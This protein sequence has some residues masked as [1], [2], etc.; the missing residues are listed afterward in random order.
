MGAVLGVMET[1]LLIV[2]NT[3]GCTVGLLQ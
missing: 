1:I 2:Q 3:A